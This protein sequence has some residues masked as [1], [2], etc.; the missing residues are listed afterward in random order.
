MIL[1]TGS[2]AFDFIMNFSGRFADQI[3]PEKIHILNLSFLTEKLH[4]NFGGTAGNIAYNLS[5]LGQETAIMASAGKDFGTYKQ[6]LKRSQVEVSY[7]KVIKNDFTANYFAVVDKSDN[8]IG[9]F[10]AGAMSWDEKLSFKSPKLLKTLEFVIIS[11]TVPQAMIKFAQ[12]CQ[13]LNIP[14]MFDPGM[15]LPRLTLNQLRDGISGAKILIGNDYEVSLILKKLK[16]NKK[17]LLKKDKILITTL[18]EKGSLIETKNK[19][20]VI[21]AAKPK[22]VVDPVGAGDAYRA[23]FIA[24][25]QKEFDLET[26]GQMG[27]VTA[28]YTVEKYGT[29]TH[30]F[31]RKQFCGRFKE[32]FGKELKL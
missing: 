14:Y 10:Y 2:L 1:V 24:G 29:T 18:A 7:I 9:G 19:S 4:K 13:K 32:N 12:E 16:F 15:Q 23:G 5:L 22:A 6:F 27:A 20:T 8:Q 31:S 30:H 26:C 25:Y 21:K 17:Q 11:P 28:V 3:M